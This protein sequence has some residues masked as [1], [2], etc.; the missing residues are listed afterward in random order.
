MGKIMKAGKVCILLGGRYSGKKA[1]IVKNS[2]DGTTDRP[3][4]H[5]LVAG[6]EKYPRKVTRRMSK[7]RIGIKSRLRPFLKVKRLNYNV[8]R[9][10]PLFS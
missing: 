1:I 6:I 4:G 2:D 5:A 9:Y 3:Y 8:T 10:M 7:K